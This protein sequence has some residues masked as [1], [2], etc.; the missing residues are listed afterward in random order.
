[1]I[2]LT[3]GRNTKMIKEAPAGVVL[4]RKGSA[5]PFSIY[6]KPTSRQFTKIKAEDT[7]MTTV[8]HTNTDHNYQDETT[9]YWFDVDLG[10]NEDI[11][12]Y[13]ISDCNGE[14]TLLDDECYPID[15][16]N[17]PPGLLKLLAPHYQNIIDAQATLHLH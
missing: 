12:Q 3:C 10:S 5:A 13:A 9:T 4:R 7:N 16:C 14:L 8:A 15:P 1:M 2:I 17:H 11:E 6:Y